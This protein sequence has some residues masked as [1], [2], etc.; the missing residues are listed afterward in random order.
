M[1]REDDRDRRA[2]LGQHL[3]EAMALGRVQSRGRLVDDDDLRVAEQRL[4]DAE[5]LPHAAGV[6]R[7]RA[8]ARI[9]E[10]GLL[11]QGVNLLAPQFG[12]ADALEHREVIEQVLRRDARVDAEL[13]RQI[14][15]HAADRERVGNDVGAVEGDATGGRLLQGGD[16]PHQ[17]RF[18]GAVRPEQ[19]VHA[20][21]HVEIDPRERLNA[22]RIG[23]PEVSDLQ[24][25]R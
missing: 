16:D 21:R 7:D 9:V 22:V 25:R 4:R 2:D 13:L 10:I 12:G 18:A 3:V 1:G 11:Q 15:E 6:G 23:V 19:A 5:A 20:A 17:R 24:P 8:L 14:A